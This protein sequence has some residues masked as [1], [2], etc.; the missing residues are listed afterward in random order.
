M[1][2]YEY[3]NVGEKEKPLDRIVTDGVFALFFVQLLV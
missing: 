1:N 2:V 3:M